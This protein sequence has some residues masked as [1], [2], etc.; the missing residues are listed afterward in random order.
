[1]NLSTT[2]LGLKLENPFIAGASALTSNLDTIKRIEDAGAGALV[3]KS[4]FEEQIQIERLQLDASRYKYEDLSA[5]IARNLFAG[6]Q[7]AGPDEHLMWIR[8]T[9]E[10]VSIPVI[11]SLNAIE[12]ENWLDYA[13]KLQ[14]A[15]ADA[16]ELNFYTVPTDFLNTSDELENEQIKL[17][18]LIKQNIKIPVSVKLSPHYTN[19]LPFIAELDNLDINGYV[20]FNRFFQPDI[21]I[22]KEEHTNNAYLT[23]EN[24]YRMSLRYAGM[25]FGYV[26]G[27]IC[28]STGILSASDAIKLFLAGAQCVQ[29]VS[30]LYKYKINHLSTL[31]EDLI[32]WMEKKEYGQLSDF[33]GK[34]SRKKTADPWI[35][36]R[37][38]YINALLKGNPVK[39]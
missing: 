5:E 23:P 18:K 33:T 20:I 31:K 10:A 3:T 16:L 22:E 30:A 14:E 28:A 15:G 17:A 32:S 25:L 1:M 11:A 26:H 36:K 8:K 37:A 27:D 38:Q 13:E 34:L 6:P 12:K 7:H 29:V 4:L 35:Y 21:N 9:K 2:Y 24:E 39:A 19:P